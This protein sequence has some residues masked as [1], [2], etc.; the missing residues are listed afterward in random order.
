VS[1][2]IRS[3]AA[4]SI[5]LGQIIGAM[6]E[7]GDELIVYAPAGV[8]VLPETPVYLVDEENGEPPA[9]TVYVLGLILVKEVLRVWSAWRNGAKPSIAQACE[10]V[11]HY[12]KYD[13][14]LPA[15]ATG[16]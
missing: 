5:P 9:G 13:A 3:A 14:Y 7:F 1:V 12:A 2:D 6:E 15:S 11:L 10:A 4:G 16:T 8:R